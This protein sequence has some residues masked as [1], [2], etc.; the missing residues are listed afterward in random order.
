MDEYILLTELGK[1]VYGKSC[2]CSSQTSIQVQDHEK[3]SENI[4]KY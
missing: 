2:A 1:C 3:E 4:Q